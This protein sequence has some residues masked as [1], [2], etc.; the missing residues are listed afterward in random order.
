MASRRDE[1]NAYTFAKKRTVASFLQPTPTGTEEGAPRPLRGFLPGL[2]VGA[3]ILAGF[4]AWGMFKPKAPG[5]WDAPG[6]H[7]IIGSESTTRYVVLKTGDRKQLHP[8]LNFASARLLLD[9]AGTDIVEV[10]EKVLDSGKVPIGPTLG[11]PYAPDRLPSGQEA[12]KA[13][14]WAV[15]EQPGAAAGSVQQATFVLAERDAHRV[16]GAGRL[17]GGEVMY[18]QSAQSDTLYLIDGSGTKYEI[19]TEERELLLRSLVGGDSK[20]Q[21]VSDQWLGT[22]DDGTPIAFPDLPGTIGAPAGVPGLEESANRIGMV[23]RAPTG[24]GPQHYVVLAQ[25]VVPV[26]DFTARLL[27]DR[28]GSLDLGQNGKAQDVAAQ[29]FTAAPAAQSPTADH[30]W[31]RLRAQQVNR[32][33]DA[34]VCSVLRTVKGDGSKTLSTWTSDAYPVPISDGTTSAY[35]TPGSGL[36][37]R[38]FQGSNT[39]T[40]GTFLVTDTGLRYAVQSNSDSSAEQQPAGDDAEDSPANDVNQAQIRLGYEDVAPVPVPADWAQFLPTGPRLDTTSAK[41]PQGA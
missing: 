24:S 39:K 21:Q 36:L 34:T 3:V 38:Q 11:I 6:K 7:V 16:D 22:F 18:V 30:H 27:L 8:V 25:Q 17:T 1:L 32:A 35:V 28:P 14:R 40:G 10:D 26:T 31:P 23:L 2:I 37:F 13:K 9:G 19:R 29:S 5:N 20:P 33:S 12:G 15:C 41:Q 4:G